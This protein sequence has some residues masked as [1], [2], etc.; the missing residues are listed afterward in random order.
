MKTPLFFFF[1]RQFSI[2]HVSVPWGVVLLFKFAIVVYY[3]ISVS[4]NPV[5]V[6]C[7]NVWEFSS[8]ELV[9]QRSML[10]FYHDKVFTRTAPVNAVTS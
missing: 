2:I 3:L 4:M 5:C 9:L 8:P 7:G 1:F 6:I 10:N